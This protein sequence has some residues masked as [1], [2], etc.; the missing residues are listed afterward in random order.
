[1][2]IIYSLM[3]FWQNH[4]LVICLNCQSF[5]LIYSF[6]GKCSQSFFPIPAFL[7]G[8]IPKSTSN[9]ITSWFL[10]LLPPSLLMNFPEQ[11]LTLVFRFTLW[12]SAT[13]ISKMFNSSILSPTLIFSK[14][15]CLL[16]LDGKSQ[17][18]F[19]FPSKA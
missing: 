6:V 16:V 7:N 10:T 1:M 4:L 11:C 12:S 5:L 8:L 17:Y 19:S 9:T 2:L 14:E 18:H 3:N 13:Y 15:I